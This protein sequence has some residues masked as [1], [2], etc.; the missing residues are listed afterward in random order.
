MSKTQPQPRAPRGAL[1]GSSLVSAALARRLE[2]SGLTVAFAESC[3]GGLLGAALTRRAGASDYFAGSAVCYRETAKLRVLGVPAR[4]LAAHGAVSAACAQAMAQG[5]LKIFGT[6]IALSVTG[7]AGPDGERVGEVW[8]GWAQRGATAQA[9]AFHFK[10]DRAQVREKAA[11][12]VLKQLAFLLPK[13][14]G[15]A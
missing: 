9:Q 13:A 2:T 5:A 7:F 1:K 15:E 4:V 11:R 8:V 3:T 14:A 12:A 6:D 10:G